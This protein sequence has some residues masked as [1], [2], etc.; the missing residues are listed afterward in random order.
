MTNINELKNLI[1]NKEAELDALKKEL[2]NA[3]LFNAN[4]N[5]RIMANC[6]F[7]SIVTEKIAKSSR[8]FVI[9]LILPTENAPTIPMYYSA[10]GGSGDNGSIVNSKDKATKFVATFRDNGLLSGFVD[11][12]GNSIDYD[13]YVPGTWFLEEV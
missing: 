11:K 5:G 12:D 7:S 10:K 2:N 1:E 9:R 6:E 8:E 4:E 13:F 3:T